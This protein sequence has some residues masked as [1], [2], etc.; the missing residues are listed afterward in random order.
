MM[1][2]SL[3]ALLCTFAVLYV[4]AADN[5]LSNPDFEVAETNSLFG[6]KFDDWSFGSGIAIET[7]DVYSGTQAFRTTEVKQTRSLEQ[8]VDLQTDVTGQEFEMTIH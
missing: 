8:T 4:S 7:Q 3:L 5:L 1:K 2:K 6:A